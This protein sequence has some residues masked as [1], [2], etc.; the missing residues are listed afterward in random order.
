MRTA[1][2]VPLIILN[3]WAAV[4]LTHR[5]MGGPSAVKVV[6][7]KSPSPLAQMPEAGM[8]LSAGFR[9]AAVLVGTPVGATVGAPDVGATVCIGLTLSVGLP[10]VLVVLYSGKKYSPS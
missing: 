6:S 5:G 2:V 10:V 3:R 1:A 9:W 8:S 4:T 7:T